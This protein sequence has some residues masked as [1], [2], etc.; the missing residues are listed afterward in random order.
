MKERVQRA[1][2][3]RG[4]TATTGMGISCGV[5]WGSLLCAGIALS[6]GA[7]GEEEPVP[8]RP[9]FEGTAFVSPDIIL[10]TDP[11]AFRELVAKGQEPR[12]MFDRRPD[13][14]GSYDAHLFDARFGAEKWVEF[15]VNPEYTPPAAE[16]QA[17]FFA[18][19]IGRLPAFLFT[20]LETVWIHRGDEAFGG[21]NNNILIH[22]GA[23]FDPAFLEE[24]LVHEATHTSM[25]GAHAGA[26]RWRSAQ[27]ADPVA[28]SDYAAEYPDREDVAET[29]LLHLALRFRPDRLRAPEAS[30]I[31]RSIPNRL[32]Y[33]DRLNLSMRILE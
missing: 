28:I 18:E 16:R 30:R 17:T 12:Q 23:R 29:V 1:T 25:D 3:I 19:A 5:R 31:E 9:P 33:L 6:I 14:F 4:S 24:V 21:G 10:D 26:S 13:A 2:S 22:T 32:D 15:Q 11:T 27:R 20:D 8:T 7:C